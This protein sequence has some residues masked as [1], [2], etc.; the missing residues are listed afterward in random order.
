MKNK[1]KSHRLLTLIRITPL[2]LFFSGLVSSCLSPYQPDT[3]SIGRAVVV[4]GMITDQPGPYFVNLTQTADYT[5]SGLNLLVT[6]AT[7]TLSDNLGNQEILKEATP[8]SYQT[9]ANG[10]RG[11]AGRSYKI[12]IR[13]SAGKQYE[14]A[15]ELLKA[16]PPI[17]KLSSEYKYNP[18]AFSNDLRNYWE[19]YL[20]TKD[21]ETPGDYYRWVWKNYEMTPACQVSPGLN[22]DG[23]YTGIP[24]CTACWNI[25]QCYSNCI[26]ISSDA[27]INGKAISRQYIL[28][29]PFTSRS[30]YYV[31]VEQQS[32]SPGAY[33]FFSSVQKLVNN[34]GGLFDSAPA[35]V[36]G[37][38]KCTS[39][40]DE[41]VYG[42]FGAAGVSVLPLRVDRTKDAVGVPNGKVIQL[43]NLAACI[44]CMNS[45]NRTPTKPRFWDQ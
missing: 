7:V 29:V 40:P 24:C 18:A 14:S 37:N 33:R 1:L 28:S 21:P 35:T 11:I 30:I 42:Y 12:T 36:G 2:L 32:I 19:V 22:A 26:N 41:V 45:I 4:E 8:G 38:M 10:I 16:A 34:T 3:Q 15:L 20:D 44:P 17:T 43:D 27:A 9:A 31:E 23:A 6:G 5:Y 25:N 39:D 13:T